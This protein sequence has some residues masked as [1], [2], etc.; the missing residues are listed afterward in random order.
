MSAHDSESYDAKSPVPGDNA[1]VKIEAVY[2]PEL[3][4]AVENTKLDGFSARSFKVRFLTFL[5]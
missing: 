5:V 1:A 3:K 2:N 4:A